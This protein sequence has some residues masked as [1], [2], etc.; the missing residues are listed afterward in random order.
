[1]T[2]YEYFQ[3]SFKYFQFS[4]L[5]LLLFIKKSKI[6]NVSKIKLFNYKKLNCNKTLQQITKDC[7]TFNTQF[8]THNK[9]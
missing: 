5:L 8:K 1:M 9:Y 3:Y 2:F 7:K 6:N 4:L